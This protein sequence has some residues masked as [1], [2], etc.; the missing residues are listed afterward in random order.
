VV[1][2]LLIIGTIVTAWTGRMDLGGANLPLALAIATVKASLVVLFFM[3]MTEAA[4]ANR[5]VFVVS[6]LFLLLM[7][8]GVF[9]DLLTRNE[10]TLPSV[11][12]TL[13]QT[14]APSVE[15]PR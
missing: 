5:I 9:G 13:E 2:V 14:E 3:H 11:T 4:G 15:E 7:L 12:P 1:W 6:L 8:A 10:M